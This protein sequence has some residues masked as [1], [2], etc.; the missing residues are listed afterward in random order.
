MPFYRHFGWRQTSMPAFVVERSL[1]GLSIRHLTVLQH[2]LAEASRRLTASGSHVRYRGTMFLPSRSRSI[3][4]FDAP[5]ADLV[6][7]VNETAQVPFVAI[8]E[9]IEVSGPE[10]SF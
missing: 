7:L 6:K 9:A 5:S 4:L 10:A 2:A 3:C 1:P 8:T